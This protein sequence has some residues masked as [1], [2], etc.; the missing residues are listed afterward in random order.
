[1]TAFAYN[2]SVHLNINCAFNE[3]FKNYVADF[4]NESENKFIKKNIFDYWKSRVIAK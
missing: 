2:N 4:A 3:L 1:M